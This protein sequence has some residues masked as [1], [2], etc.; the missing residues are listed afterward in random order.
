MSTSQNVECAKRMVVYGFLAGWALFALLAT[1]P[2][3]VPVN[4]HRDC[5]LN[6]WPV[7]SLN[8]ATYICSPYLYLP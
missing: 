1:V 6:H 4:A 7:V 5:I 8:A 3:E 2:V